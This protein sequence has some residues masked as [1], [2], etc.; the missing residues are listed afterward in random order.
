MRLNYTSEDMNRAKDTNLVELAK[1]LGYTPVRCGRFYSLKEMDSIRLYNERT[2]YRWSGSGNKTGGTQIDFIMEYGN[3]NNI[4]EAVHLLLNFQG[5]SPVNITH[6]TMN[7]ERETSHFT[8]PSKAHSYRIM[9]AYLM[10]QRGLSYD[11][12]NYFVNE[13]KILY[14]SEEHHNLVFCGRDTDGNIKFATQRGTGDIYGRRF[15]G[16]VLGSDKN[17]GISIVNNVSSELYVFEA[18]IDC[19]SYIDITGDY[20]SNKLI[21]NCLEENA[22]INFLDKNTNINKIIFCIDN[23]DKAKEKMYGKNAITD[24]NGNVIRDKVVGYKERYENKGYVV[25]DRLAPEY[26]QCKDYND[27]LKYLKAT[28]PDMVY[29]CNAKSYKQAIRK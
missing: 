11:V 23:D 22:L 18:S 12:I 25:E 6:S 24:L 13:Q 9:Y 16:D 5:I 1:A 21:L 26:P 28:R 14:E 15:R 10:K 8:L 4:P 27:V 17:V 7:D 3:A 29:S 2:W 19:M 20:R